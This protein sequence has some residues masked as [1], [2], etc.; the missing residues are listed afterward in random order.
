MI[1]A[2]LVALV[3]GTLYWLGTYLWS[4]RV[5]VARADAL[6]TATSTSAGPILVFSG[7]RAGL[8]NAAPHSRMVLCRESATIE[9]YK[10]NGESEVLI[11]RAD[12]TRTEVRRGLGST[13]V[14]FEVRGLRDSSF[15]FMAMPSAGLREAL[16]E[17]GWLDEQ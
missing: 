12:V 6:Q 8:T 3:L 15:G 1:L 9:G 7:K 5:H 16:K 17:L 4:W 13:T 14:R 2:V 11:E 10:R